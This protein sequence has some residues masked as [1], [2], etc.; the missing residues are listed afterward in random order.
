[1][2]RPVSQLSYPAEAPVSSPTIAPH[3]SFNAANHPKTSTRI[4]GSGHDSHFPLP[5]PAHDSRRR[6]KHES[7]HRDVDMA[8][9]QKVA[10]ALA[11]VQ[12]L[13]EEHGPAYQQI[14]QNIREL[15]TPADVVDDLNAISDAFLGDNLGILDIRR[16]AD[17]HI[18]AM[19]MSDNDDVVMNVGNH[20]LGLLEGHAHATS[21]LDGCAVIRELIAGCLERQGDYKAAATVLGYIQVDVSNRKV[22]D[23]EK[24]GLWVRI[25]RNL[26]E[27]DDTMTADLFI[28]RLKNIM[29]SVKNTELQL[30]FNLSQ[31]RVLDA[32]RDFNPASQRYHEISYSTAIAEE[33][34]LHTLS[35]AIKCAILAPAG[36]I[37]SRQLS[38]LYKDERSQQLA[39]YGT[40]EKVYLDRLIS[41]ADAAKFAEGL[42]EHHRATT[43]DGST[44]FGKAM[45]EHNLLG[46]SKLYSNIRFDALGALLGLDADKAEE[47]TARMIEQGRLV[48]R[49]DQL[50]GIVHFE[51]A[52]ASGV[53]GSGRA[54]KIVGKQ[55]RQWDGNILLLAEEVESI[56]NALQERFP[57]G[58][59]VQQLIIA[60]RLT[61]FRSSLRGICLS[62]LVI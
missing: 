19:R 23:E 20:L 11:R 36:P 14:L 50:A 58:R 46:A 38:R 33:E 43:A 28:N 32:K 55:T 4:P 35:M 25:V 3:A 48:G 52:E 39:E 44:V 27:V 21:Y 30:H 6:T 29:H 8:P 51:T 10:Q 1:M 9:S 37:R 7:D 26:L 17:T 61:K 13:A 56:T 42:E 57:V 49:M 24:A 53:K 45:M 47:T 12:G 60:A 34:R 40:L 16:L 54:E 18:A 15:S 2:S 62:D 41:P 22:S 5:R 31:A 59:S